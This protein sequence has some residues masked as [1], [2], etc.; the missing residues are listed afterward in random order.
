MKDGVE[1]VLRFGDLRMDT[2]GQEAEKPAADA[3]AAE[4]A[5]AGDKNVQ[6][7]LFAMARF[8]ED[9]IKKPDLQEL[10]PLPADEPATPGAESAA[11]QPAEA[12]PEAAK[13]E[14]PE[15]AQAPSSK[16]VAEPVEEEE[17]EEETNEAQPAVEKSDQASS[18]QRAGDEEK[19][20]T[21]EP[22]K[23]ADATKDKGTAERGAEAKSVP[24]HS[25]DYER[26]LAQRK[27]IETENKRKLDE[28][29]AL[30]EKGRKEVKDLNLRF[31]DWYFVVSNDTF[32]KI[33]L[34]K[35][36][37]VKKKDAK[38]DKATTEKSGPAGTPGA[39]IPGLPSLPSVDGK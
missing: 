32:K 34:G 36:E 7:Y 28:Y 12:K 19:P 6:R 14:K 30:V 37:V 10:P 21:A 5:K 8:N 2:S 20:S 31:G 22:A 39:A 29:H 24:K 1:Y 38:A 3:T 35:D 4:K 15:A 18:L 25:P 23:D 13:P 17:E 27:Q 11:P 9:A 26:V 33:R 16:E